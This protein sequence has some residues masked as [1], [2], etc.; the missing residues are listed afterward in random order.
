MNHLPKYRRHSN[1]QAFVQHKS[2]LTRDHRL[3]LGKYG[4]PESQRR[5]RQFLARLENTADKLELP[6]GHAHTLAGLT[7]LLCGVAIQFLGL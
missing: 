5:Y 3:Y 6:V 2:I 4:S 1:G 7:I